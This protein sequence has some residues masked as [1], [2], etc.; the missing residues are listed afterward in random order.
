MTFDQ[1]VWNPILPAAPVFIIAFALAGLGIWNI[2]RKK[3]FSIPIKIIRSLILVLT[4]VLAVTINMRPM[5]ESYISDVPRKDMDVLFV[6]DTTVSMWANDSAC[7]RIDAAIEDC[8]DIMKGLDGAG[9]GL[10]RF[11][12]EAMILAPFTTDVDNVQDALETLEQPDSYYA[13]G[14]SINTPY[15]AMQQ[16]L[17]SSAKKE[18]RVTIVFFLGDGEITD[19]SELVSYKELK[20][21]VDGGAVLGYGTAEGGTMKS[22]YG[23]V[24]GYDENGNFG[25]GVSK[26]NEENLKQIADDLGVRYVN[27][28]QK[29]SLERILRSVD[30]IAEQTIE[31]SRSA[32]VYDDLY[33]YLTLPLLACIVLEGFFS[34]RRRKMPGAAK[35]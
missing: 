3:S 21:Y 28:T 34:V 32:V 9:F 12:N 5:K 4:A 2:L 7:L 17:Q 25:E 13:K 8:R 10:I 23:T 33:Y 20:Q 15:E 24:Y 27:R 11:D 18:G 35:K 26:I 29:E 22:E 16:V 30:S 19:G 6:L 14:S 1:I 31:K